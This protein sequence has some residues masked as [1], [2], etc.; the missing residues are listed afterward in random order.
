VSAV[1][2]DA[3]KQERF[4]AERTRLLK[5]FGGRLLELRGEERTQEDVA[6]LTK[7]HPTFIGKLERGEQEPG[8]LTIRIIADALGVSA[9]SLMRFPVPQERRAHKGGK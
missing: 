5:Q 4:D 8:L 1:E 3:A 9:D 6:A 2:S 7:L